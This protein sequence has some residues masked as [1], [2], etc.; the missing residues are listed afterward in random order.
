MNEVWCPAFGLQLQ[1][2]FAEIDHS[3]IR[4][5]QRVNKTPDM[6]LELKKNLQNLMLFADHG[7]N[8]FQM[9]CPPEK[10]SA[11]QHEYGSSMLPLA[12]NRKKADHGTKCA[13]ILCIS[14]RCFPETWSVNQH[15]DASWM[16]SLACNRQKRNR[17]DCWLSAVSKLLEIKNKQRTKT[18]NWW[19]W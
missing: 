12:C 6:G 18:N 2:R 7:T 8:V 11:N 16:L 13:V 19:C 9:W 15:E 4:H 5:H 1:T 17:R 14:N 10:W 3:R